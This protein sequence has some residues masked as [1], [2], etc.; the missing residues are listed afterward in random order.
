MTAAL[1]RALADENA[2]REAHKKRKLK[3]V[4]PYDARHQFGHLIATLTSDECAT[5]DLM[6][7]STNAQT[8]RYTGGAGRVRMR[9]AIDLVAATA[10]PSGTDPLFWQYVRV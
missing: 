9:R 7:H 8:R 1:A 10:D 3:G 5:Q 6:L 4:R 2:W